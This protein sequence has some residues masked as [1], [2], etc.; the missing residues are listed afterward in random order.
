MKKKRDQLDIRVDL[1]SRR[2]VVSEE[3]GQGVHIY[4][5]LLIRRGHPKV[6]LTGKMAIARATGTRVMSS[7]RQPDLAPRV[8]GQ[9]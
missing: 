2:K 6:I 7:L 3:C 1:P 5:S 8:E 9:N 4:F